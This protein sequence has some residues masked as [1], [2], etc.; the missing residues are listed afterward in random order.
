MLVVDGIFLTATWKRVPAMI[1][2]LDAHA[3]G[4]TFNHL[5]SFKSSTRTDGLCWTF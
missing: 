4:K 5:F 3:V 1:R 2:I